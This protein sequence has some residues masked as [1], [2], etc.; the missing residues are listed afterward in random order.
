MIRISKP[1]ALLYLTTPNYL[2]LMGLYLIYDV[3]LKKNRYSP[4]TQQIDHRWLFLLIPPT[5][6]KR[7]ME[8]PRVRQG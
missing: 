3:I 4:A 1:G 7:W 8:D 5:C 6:R 2:N